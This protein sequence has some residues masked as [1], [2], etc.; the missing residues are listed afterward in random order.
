MKLTFEDISTFRDK[1]LADLVARCDKPYTLSP[2][3]DSDIILTI[4]KI[5][6]RFTL[7]GERKSL[8]VHMSAKE[9]EAA[10]HIRNLAAPISWIAR[11]SNDNYLIFETKSTRNAL[12]Q[13]PRRLQLI[14]DDS[15]AYSVA[16]PKGDMEG[17]VPMYW[18]DNKSNFGDEIGP[19]LATKITGI[20]SVNL[21]RSEINTPTIMSVGSIFAQIE[22]GDTEVWGSGLISQLSKQQIDSLKSYGEIKIHALRGKLSAIEIQE[23]LG[24]FTPK[25]YGDPGL[26]VPKHMKVVLDR[27]L[28]S[29][30]GF[31]PH[32]AHDSLNVKKSSIVHTI[33]VG[34]DLESVAQQISQVKCIVSTSLHGI[35]L[36]QAFGVPWIWLRIMDKPLKGD[37]FKFQDF[38]STLQGPAPSI[39]ETTS[40]DEIDVEIIGKSATLPQ[41]GI[42]LEDLENSF[43]HHLVPSSI[44]RNYYKNTKQ[45]LK[46]SIP[47]KRINKF[48]NPFSRMNRVIRDSMKYQAESLA[49]L[50]AIDSS[51][52]LNVQEVSKLRNENKQLRTEVRALQNEAKSIRSITDALRKHS[53]SSL[54]QEM[55]AML[56]DRQKSALETI[57]ALSANN[58]SFARFG[59]GEFRLLGHP[60]QD[61]SFQD[62]S[63]ELRQKLLNVLSSSNENLLIGFPQIYQDNNWSSIWAE[64]WNDVKCLIPAS[65][66]WGN[67][68][69]T[70]PFVFKKYRSE[71][72][73]AWRSVWADKS[74]CVITGKSS[75][76]E[77]IPEL[78]DNVAS[79]HRIDSVDKNAF[80]DIDR[81]LDMA[82]S[83]ETDMFL[84]ALGPAGTILAHELANRGLRGLDIGHLSDSY[85]N[86]FQNAKRP[87]AKPLSK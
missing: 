58:L 81:I 28:N 29:K 40:G 56:G 5:K 39:Y 53:Q 10:R 57:R 20:Q 11:T 9:R 38:F 41:L 21:R 12:K 27:T 54:F 16:S 32:Y 74:V 48:M 87:E 33:D 35:I 8:K 44:D 26:L 43:P 83:T 25:V 49:V 77:F 71:A 1:I 6:V 66:D 79:V 7:I 65:R 15:V 18:W 67:A 4:N 36:S 14:I 13:L 69:V 31:V 73:M 86:V 64:I 72:V 45:V 78:F 42:S 17:R 23:K 34:M 68:H 24:W 82:E 2:D 46:N 85:L 59:D 76:F 70:R 37:D 75:R 19:W 62:N 50:K 63:S 22:N 80:E 61:I 55:R 47:R 60:D 52:K 30:I 51:I 3:K 84:I